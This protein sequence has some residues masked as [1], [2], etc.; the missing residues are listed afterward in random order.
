M[1]SLEEKLD[2][3]KPVV[4]IKNLNFSYDKGKPNITGLN[5]VIE[6]NS[7]VI[8]V[9][10]NGAG[11]STLLRILTGVIFMGLEHDEFDI[12]GT[13]RP[14]DQ[15]NGIAYLGGA[16][17]RR[18]TGF[19]GI[20][21]Y[22]MDIAARD[23]MGKWQDENKERRDELVRVMGI[24]LDWRM[25]ECSDG[26]RKKVRIM[27]KLLRPF[28]LCVIDE[29]AAD[30]DIFSRK[31]LFDYLTDQ[32]ERFGASVVYA[33]HI[34]DQ[35]DT[36][37][38]HIAFMQLDKVLSPLHRLADYAPYQEVLARSGK[39][40]SM[41]PMYDLVHEELARQYRAASDLFTDEQQCVTDVDVTDYIMAEQ[42]A[43]RAGD[44]HEVAAEGA[45]SGYVHGRLA[46]ELALQDMADEARA[47]GAA[48]RAASLA[49]QEAV[50]KVVEDAA[51]S[52]EERVAKLRAMER[53]GEL[54]PIGD[55]LKALAAAIKLA[56]ASPA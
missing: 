14:N 45:A 37:A 17:K 39:E 48:K 16:W 4:T 7:K 22:T 25:H 54:S 35:A 15:A 5:C 50:R 43:E 6:P 32:C 26:Q 31:R 1:A 11:K 9:G 49:A 10:A 28:K 13:Q 30:L 38:T 40:R 21:P 18:R 19:D 34:F 46:R 36:W 23:M 47:A 55:S 20:C 53:A 42:R 24:N 56:E 29:F 51:L 41:C 8:L 3:A 12:N 33:T 27:I 44:A 52:L 2:A